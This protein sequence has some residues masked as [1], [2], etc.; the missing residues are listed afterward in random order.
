MNMYAKDYRRIS[1]E[2]LAGNW[3]ISILVA[4]LASLLGGAITGS[5]FSIDVDTE[6]LQ[7]LPPFLTKLLVLWGSVAST[8]SLAQLV[9]GGPVKLGNC[10]YLLNQQDGTNADLKDLFSEFG[11]WGAGFVLNLLTNLYIF[12]WS[13]LFVIPGIVASYKYAMAPFIL[14]ENPQMS[15][16][17]AIKASKELM[18][19]HKLELFCL[20]LSFIGWS[21]L[22]ALTAGI[23]YL[24]L[25]PYTA[26]SHAAF[27]RQLC[28]NTAA[29]QP[30]PE[31]RYIPPVEF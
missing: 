2:K 1:R 30:Q 21:I 16:S 27:Y 5:S 28:P 17:E 22:A 24:F 23:G 26:A 29:S 12:L 13:L 11:R 18:N 20:D 31:A 15:A 4:F 7:S 10:H 3:G 6:L 8:L 9:V 14:A 25:N 19:G